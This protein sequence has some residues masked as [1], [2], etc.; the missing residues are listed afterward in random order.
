MVVYLLALV[1]TA[2]IRSIGCTKSTR[3]LSSVRNKGGD[4]LAARREHC[5]VVLQLFNTT[6]SVVYYSAGTLGLSSNGSS[7]PYR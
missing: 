7:M 6:L 1:R 3:G 4:M 5:Q 2:A